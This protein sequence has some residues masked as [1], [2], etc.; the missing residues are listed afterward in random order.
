MDRKEVKKL[1]SIF[2]KISSK[3]LVGAEFRDS[4][5]IYSVIGFL[6]AC[7]G[8]DQAMLIGNLGYLL[9]QQG[10]NTCIVD[11]KVFNPNLYYLFG[12]DPPARGKGLIRV[13]KSDKA[14]MREDIAPTSEENLYLLSPSP[15]DLLEEYFEFGFA[16][17]EQVLSTLK[18]MFDIILLDI[19]YNPPLEF[20]TGAMKHCHIGYFTAAE[21]I[22]A[23]GNMTKLLDFAAS[24]G[25]STAKFTSVIMM[26][27]HEIGL[28]YKVFKQM[29]F[30]IAAAL[31]FVK[32]AAAY[33]QDGKLY[34]KDHP[35][36]NKAFMKE[37]NRLRDSIINQ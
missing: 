27:L 1:E 3:E 14:D 26:N 33:T 2:R 23:P 15:Y 10:F 25:I 28:D 7:E 35:L 31:P 13:L 5:L 21:R 30:Q 20:C 17:I 22:E 11:F 19:P 24:I 8:T 6:P 29:G 18:G 16:H 4:P 34:V 37:M 32:A 12:V 36:Q 9:A